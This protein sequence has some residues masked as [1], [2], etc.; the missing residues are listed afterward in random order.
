M[1]TTASADNTTASSSTTAADFPT[2]RLGRDDIGFPTAARESFD[3]LWYRGGADLT[4]LVGKAPVAIIGSTA[5]TD[6]GAQVATTL[7][8]ELARAG[9]P[10]ITP[11]GHGIAAAAHR[12]ALA[13]GADGAPS[14][15]VAPGGLDRPNP[16]GNDQKLTEAVLEAGGLMLSPFDAGTPAAGWRKIVASR[17]LVALSATVVV[18]EAGRRCGALAA[19]RHA[20]AV[21]VP[22]GRDPR[23]G[24][25]GDLGRYQPPHRR[26]PRTAGHRCRRDRAA[27]HRPGRPEAPTAPSTGDLPGPATGTVTGGEPAR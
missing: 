13:A 11:S 9:H 25:L 21:G 22:V 7:A 18:V 15:V 12:G 23:P 8:T 20:Y 17:L 10:V 19:A 3:E 16:V 4:S 14:I 2:I 24:D 26:S 1:N 5:A 6:Y 27:G